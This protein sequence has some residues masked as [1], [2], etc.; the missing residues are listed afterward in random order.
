ML[1]KWALMAGKSISYYL[2]RITYKRKRR[3]IQKT[4]QETDDKNQFNRAVKL[5]I[6]I[7]VFNFSQQKIKPQNNRAQKEKAMEIYPKKLNKRKEKKKL[8]LL[9]DKRHEE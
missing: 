2:E 7:F 4:S 3:R 8:S 1:V 9:E 6:G 5:F